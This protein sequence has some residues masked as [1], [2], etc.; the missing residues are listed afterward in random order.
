MNFFTRKGRALLIIAAV[1]AVGAAGWMAGCGDGGA[2]PSGGGKFTDDRDGKSYKTVKIGE[3]TWMAE[4]LNYH[5]P[6]ETD[7]SWC[8]DNDDSNCEIYGRLY[9]WGTAKKACPAGWHLP[10][11]AEWG[12][13]AIAAG[14]TGKYGDGGTAGKKLKATSGWNDKYDGASGNGTDEFGFSAL[15]SGYR[16]SIGGNFYN[17]GDFGLWW[18][19]TEYDA[20]RANLRY[21]YYNY[22]RVAETN[23]L[24]DWGLAVRCVRD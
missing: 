6:G 8:Y 15:P 9:V 10:S 1:L 7:S 19:A 18:T 13:L 17:V 14:G 4:N 12:E 5:K 21:M 23:Y 16:H 2:G 22:D 3:Q 24:R 20:S 11:M